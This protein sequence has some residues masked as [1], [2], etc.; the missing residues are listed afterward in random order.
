MIKNSL[1]LSI[2]LKYIYLKICSLKTKNL[3]IKDQGWQVRQ[4][5][6]KNAGNTKNIC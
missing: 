6:E 4:E 2:I 1:G 5:A 3:M